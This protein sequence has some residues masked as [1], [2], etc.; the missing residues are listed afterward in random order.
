MSS[1]SIW[2]TT[3]PAYADQ[4]AAAHRARPVA[5]RAFVRFVRERFRVWR[6]HRRRIAALRD[7]QALDD[8]QLADI[9]LRRAMIREAV[10]GLLEKQR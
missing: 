2:Q 9:G 7:L 5:S 8:R 3:R 4:M 6:R 1:G 10:D